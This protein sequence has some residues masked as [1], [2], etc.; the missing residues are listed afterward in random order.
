MLALVMY[1]EVQRRAQADIDRVVGSE[2]LPNFDDRPALPYIDAI[3][4]EVLRMHPPL[5]IGMSSSSINTP[6][7]TLITCR[8]P[9]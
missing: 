6:K 3:I 8:P 9:T 5:P 1:P 4:K 7:S 2:R